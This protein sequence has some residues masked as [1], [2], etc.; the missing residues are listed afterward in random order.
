MTQELR[1]LF[2]TDDE[3]ATRFRQLFH[4]DPSAREL[5]RFRVADARLQLRLH[6]QARRRVARLIATI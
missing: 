6:H 4:R 5:R 1:L 3:L 2:P